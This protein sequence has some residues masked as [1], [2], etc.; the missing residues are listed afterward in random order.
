MQFAF[1]DYGGALDSERQAIALFPVARFYSVASEAAAQLR[2]DEVAIEFL[3]EGIVT[4]HSNDLRIALVR[5]LIDATRLPEARQVL[6]DVLA[7]DP[8]NA[9]ALELQR[10]IGA[11]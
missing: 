9:P 3:R 6:R 7:L 10:Q 4:T 8:T 5:R 2:D 1:G 11:Q